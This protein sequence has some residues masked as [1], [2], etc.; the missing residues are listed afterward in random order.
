MIENQWDEL[1]S[2]F[3]GICFSSGRKNEE[4]E[5]EKKQANQ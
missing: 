4:W 5:Q 3:D 1:G 2:Y